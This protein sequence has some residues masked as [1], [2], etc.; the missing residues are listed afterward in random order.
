VTRRETDRRH[1]DRRQMEQRARVS[2]A[3]AAPRGTAVRPPEHRERV[4]P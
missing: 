3:Q 2:G 1:G 4:E